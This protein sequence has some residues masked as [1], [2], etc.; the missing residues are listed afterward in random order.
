[1]K[2]WSDITRSL[3]VAALLLLASCAKNGL[4]RFRLAVA[5][6]QTITGAF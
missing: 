6:L 4:I 5:N 1:M 2:R 3:T